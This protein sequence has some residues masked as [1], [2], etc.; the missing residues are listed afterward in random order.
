MDPGHRSPL[1]DCFRR[2]EVA[3]DIR[4]QAA[5]GLMALPALERVALLVL[6]TDDQDP[7]ILA[8]AHAT[9]AALPEPALK[10]FLARD[11]VP[12]EIR[13]F[14]GERSI[15]P[16]AEADRLPDHER[17]LESEP[18]SEES[19]EEQQQENAPLANLSILE[20]IKLAMKGSREQRQALIRDPNKM[21]S[22]AVLS[23]PKLTESE[24][25][26]FARMANVSEDVLRT[27]GMNRTWTKNYSVI[28]AL[29]RNPKTPPAISLNMVG[30]LNE[31]D[32]KTITIDR[33]VPE[34]LR[35]AA[36][37]FLV[38]PKGKG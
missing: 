14:F 7:E 12:A 29:T 22:A 24:I 35:L 20:R 9:I 18:T 13:Q 26:S 3:R 19:E 5:Q 23:S 6:L 17:L 1:I 27:I 36:R 2:G 4:L 10:S 30:R 16:A 34:A 25:E 21:V 11:D 37:K 28:S 31:R 38:K 8:A 33:N 32:I 15:T